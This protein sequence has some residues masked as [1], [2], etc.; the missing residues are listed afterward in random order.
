VNNIDITREKVLDKAFDILSRR[1]HSQSELEAK[2]EKKE[3][4]QEYISFAIT[5]CV[6][7]GFIND[8]EFARLYCEELQFRKYGSRKIE[9][10]MMKKGLDRDLIRQTID[11]SDSDDDQYERAGE[12]LKKKMKSL[13]R[14][15]DPRK[16]REKA[17]RFLVSRGFPVSVV[18]RIIGETDF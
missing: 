8:A 18:S 9:M 14:E 3:Y 7:L 4:P 5:E 16:K 12:A 17:F 15:T 11:E 10:Y 6:R 1:P 2:L 13:S